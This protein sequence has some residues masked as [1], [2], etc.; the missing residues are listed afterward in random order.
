MAIKNAA[1]FKI[2]A[3]LT[4]S[5]LVFYAISGLSALFNYAFYP[6]ISRLVSVASY[7]EI[8][9][10]VSSFNQLAVGFVVL[11]ILAIVL[12]VKAQSIKDKNDKIQ[13]LNRIAGLIAS[14]L[15]A[16]GVVILIVF[17][18]QLQLNDPL[19]I[20]LLGIALLVNVP[21]TT[22]IGQLQGSDKFVAA[23]FV[24]LVAAVAKL[25]FSLLFIVLG[26]GTMGAVLGLVVGMVAAIALGSLFLGKKKSKKNSQSIKKH[27]IQLSPVRQQA[28]VGLVAISLLTL[29]STLDIIGS[30]II[31]SSVDAGLYAVVATLAKIIIAVGSPLMWLVLPFAIDGNVRK[32]I[33]Y[34]IIATVASSLLIGIFFINPRELVAIF[35]GVDTGGL[36]NLLP[37]LGLSMTFYSLGFI[38]F[39]ALICSE[40]LRFVITTFALLSMLVATIFIIVPVFYPLTLNHIVYIQ[41]SVGAI[42]V[43]SGLYG[44]LTRFNK[45]KVAPESV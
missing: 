42:L 43:L 29:F 39:A 32:V 26:L 24:G 23:G 34:V 6:A 28:F 21:L 30:R 33:R 45:A 3:L 36:S 4:S 31:L 9:F 10:L 13:S 41:L 19:A 40:R 2:L 11:N 7:G 38:L 25:G 18:K 16:I 37:V 17:M 27:A 8:Q 14:T 1:R 15:A 20:I 35:M 22:L 12:S 44:L 5:A